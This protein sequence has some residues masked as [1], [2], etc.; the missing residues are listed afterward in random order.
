MASKIRQIGKGY[1]II[2]FIFTAE[3]KFV[4]K[5]ID[6]VIARLFAKKNRFYNIK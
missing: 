6:K 4:Y 5:I 2:C 3:Y 1:W